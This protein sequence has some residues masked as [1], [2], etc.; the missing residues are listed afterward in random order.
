[1]YILVTFTT[2]DSA[3]MEIVMHFSVIY[4]IIYAWPMCFL[5]VTDK[6]KVVMTLQ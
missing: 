5:V 6:T 2:H 3:E 4:N 1:M